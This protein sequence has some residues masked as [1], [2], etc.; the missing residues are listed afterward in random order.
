MQ[1]LASRF[2]IG[3]LHKV[4]I[5]KKL[6]ELVLNYETIF[7]TCSHLFACPEQQG[8]VKTR[9]TIERSWSTMAAG[10]QNIEVAVG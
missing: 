5:K 2:Q 10:S 3:R 8:K 4:E 7:K 9:L 1:S 6:I